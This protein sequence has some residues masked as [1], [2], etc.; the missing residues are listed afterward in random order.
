MKFKAHFS[1]E[2]EYEV[3]RDSYPANSSVADMTA[4]DAENFSDNPSHL[5]DMLGDDAEFQVTV[6]PVEDGLNVENTFL[7]NLNNE[8]P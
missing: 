2:L 8:S 7:K 1:F 3:D 4:I 5:I 6:S